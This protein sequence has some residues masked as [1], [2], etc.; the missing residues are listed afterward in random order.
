MTEKLR[1]KGI[2]PEQEKQGKEPDLRDD[3]TL[4]KNLDC[5]EDTDCRK[6]LDYQE[7]QDCGEQTGQM[8]KNDSQEQA[9]SFLV[10]SAIAYMK[11]NYQ[12][13][14]TLTEVADHIYVSQW[15]LSKLLNRHGGQSFSELLN[16]IRVEEAKVLLKDPAL[17]IGDVAEN[18]GFL[19]LAHFSRVFKKI[20]GISANEF[21]NRMNVS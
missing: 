21:R 18:V 7:G 5:Q 1:K 13:R 16:T 3:S 15:H 10:N 4:W 20:T 11:K 12:H 6:G 14:L 9:G 19:D 17:R 8:E 2:L